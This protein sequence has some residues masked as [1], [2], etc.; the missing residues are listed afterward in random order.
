MG[1]QCFMLEETRPKLFRRSLRRYNGEIP[2]QGRSY[3]NAAT[4]IDE[5]EFETQWC[6]GELSDFTD[7]E[8]TRWPKKC[9]HCDYA[10]QAGDARQQNWELLYKLLDGSLAELRH[11]PAGAMW[12]AYWMGNFGRGPDGL[13]LT[14]ML[15]NGIAWCIDGLSRNA[16]G[17][18]GSAWTRS[19][20]P[21]NVTAS[22]SILAGNYHGWLRNGE[23]VEC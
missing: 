16:D 14:V 8:D 15:P 5:I 17:S 3:H 20:A 13:C 19:G 23:L 7:N 2:C 18:R 11:V 22:P 9:E 4:V 10:F 1:I 6:G 21:P 12:N